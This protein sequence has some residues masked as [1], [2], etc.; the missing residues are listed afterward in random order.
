MINWIASS[1]KQRAAWVKKCILAAGPVKA[2]LAEMERQAAEW[3]ARTDLKPRQ[4]ESELLYLRN[5][6]RGL[7]DLARAHGLEYQ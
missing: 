5:A 6:Y 2:Q 1:D 3:K 4:V 7:R